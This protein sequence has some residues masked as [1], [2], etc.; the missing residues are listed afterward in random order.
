MQG[1]K[2]SLCECPGLCFQ[3]NK[4][5]F[6]PLTTHAVDLCQWM[7]KYLLTGRLTSQAHVTS[8]PRDTF[9]CAKVK[10]SW[11][12]SC[13]EGSITSVEFLNCINVQKPCV[14]NKLLFFPALKPPKCRIPNLY[15]SQLCFC[16]DF[17]ILPAIKVTCTSCPCSIRLTLFSL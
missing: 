15:L 16:F 4:S 1:F 17:F 13:L 12:P 14:I 6:W 11:R 8:A 10:H 9:S 3:P 5:N 2:T 7:K